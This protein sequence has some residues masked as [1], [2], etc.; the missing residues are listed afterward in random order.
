ME[1]SPV[2]ELIRS[3]AERLTW[4]VEIYGFADIRD[5][6]TAT[7]RI[8]KRLGGLRTQQ[9]VELLKQGKLYEAFDIILD[10]YDKTYQYDLERRQV[11]MYPIDIEGLNTDESVQ[12]LIQN[13]YHI[14]RIS[15]Q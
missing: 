13:L 2:L 7:E 1:R 11:P 4:L 5:L 10:Y 8:R 14:Q 9:A 6:V 12:K 3:R 15:R